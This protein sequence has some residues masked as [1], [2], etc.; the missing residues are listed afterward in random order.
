MA[1]AASC[2]EMARAASMMGSTCAVATCG[3][4]TGPTYRPATG[5]NLFR[6]HTAHAGCSR[7][8]R[9]HAIFSE[10]TTVI[11]HCGR[12]RRRSL[13]GPSL[14]ARGLQPLA[15]H[16]SNVR[17]GRRRVDNSYVTESAEVLSRPITPSANMPQMRTRRDRPQ[18]FCAGCA[19]QAVS[20]AAIHSAEHAPCVVLCCAAVC[21]SRG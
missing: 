19:A 1:P 9:L 4:H 11:R 5:P 7:L 17:P 18:V 16:R 12:W 14:V 10:P 13:K 8:A 15:S 2:P 3:P 6:K 20:P 21:T